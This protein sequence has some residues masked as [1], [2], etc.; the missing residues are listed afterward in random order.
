MD[1]FEEMR[2]FVRIVERSSFTKAAADLQIPRA[3]MTNAIQRLEERLGT[4]LLAR[5]TRTVKPTLDGE[6]YYKR[7]VRILAE[8]EEADGIFLRCAPK[9]LLR[10]NL[11]G[12]LARMFVI[13]ALPDFMAQYPD[14]TLLIGDGDRYVD[15]VHEGYDCVLRSGELVDSSMIGR[16]LMT[17]NE[18]TVASPAY[19]EKYGM[20]REIDDLERQ[21]HRVVSF[22]SGADDKP[23][24]LDF[25]IDGLVRHVELPADVSVTGADLYMAATVAGLGII[26]V[27]RY[28]ALADLNA[29][30]LVEIMPQY[31]PEPMPVSVLYPQNR[32]LSLRVRVFTDW[33]GRLFANGVDGLMKEF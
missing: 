31:P 17:M 3:T 4:R 27:P 2:N 6:V 13:P 33:L 15:L 30:R 5:T 10:V 12:T 7:C 32:Q 29:G 9:G 25:T 22:L 14:I 21:G 8:L 28:R 1:R 26:Q 24:P 20:P 23:M 11:Q 19:I 16:R 18:V